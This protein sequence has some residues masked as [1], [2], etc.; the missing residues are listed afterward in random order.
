MFTV[1]LTPTTVPAL[2]EILFVAPTLKDFKPNLS[3]AGSVFVTDHSADMAEQTITPCYLSS[4]FK[5]TR[6]LCYR[7]D[8]RAMRPIGYIAYMTAVWF[9]RFTVL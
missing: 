7:T 6:K 8:D 4:V 2:G 5:I 3:T 1:V 9:K